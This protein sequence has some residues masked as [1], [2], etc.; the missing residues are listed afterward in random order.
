MNKTFAIS[1]Y[2]NVAEIY[3]KIDALLAQPIRSV[4]KDKMQE[5]LD[6][7]KTKC[8]KKKFVF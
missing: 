7:F 8:Q 5:Y 6:Y 2:H 3:A 1:E 4:R